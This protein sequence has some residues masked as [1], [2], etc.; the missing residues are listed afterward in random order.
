[1]DLAP[2]L[3]SMMQVWDH[4]N[5]CYDLFAYFSQCVV[6]C[7]GSESCCVTEVHILWICAQH[8]QLIYKP[9][10]LLS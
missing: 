5:M 2:I 7:L 8:N 1:M 3:W 10:H 6:F 9:Q 4:H